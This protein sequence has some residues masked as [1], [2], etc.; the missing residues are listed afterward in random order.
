MRRTIAFQSAI[1]GVRDVGRDRSCRGRARRI[2]RPGYRTPV[3]VPPE[4]RLAGGNSSAAYPSSIWSAP[5]RPHPGN[6]STASFE[7]SRPEHAVSVTALVGADLSTEH[8]EIGG[9]SILRCDHIRRDPEPYRYG[10][11]GSYPRR[12]VHRRTWTH[13]ICGVSRSCCSEHYAA[14]GACSQLIS[15]GIPN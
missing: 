15:H 13:L 2:A 14:A 8:R 12:A 11:G 3:L 5:S 1:A 4:R 10:R 7:V 6:D 9:V